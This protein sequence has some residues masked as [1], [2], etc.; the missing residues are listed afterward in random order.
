M[1]DTTEPTMKELS[2]KLDFL[3]QLHTQRNRKPRKREISDNRPDEL[4]RIFY[5]VCGLPDNKKMKQKFPVG[6]YYN[7]GTK[8]DGFIEIV[9]RSILINRASMRSAFRPKREEVLVKSAATIAAEVLDM[10]VAEGKLVLSKLDK[11]NIPGVTSQMECV[12]SPKWAA[13]RKVIGFEWSESEK[14]EDDEEWDDEEEKP[15][16]QPLR[17]FLKARGIEV[18]P[19]PQ[20]PAVGDIVEQETLSDESDVSEEE[21][22]REMREAEQADI[23]GDDVVFER[24][25]EK[26]RRKL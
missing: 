19:I 17:D 26:E 12:F 6:T 23:L 1:N 4:L 20:K 18:P 24:S 7:L 14:D 3:I 8:G 16:I 15:T 9:P 21:L 25:T 13:K 22:I 2:E 11:T 10:L 5:A